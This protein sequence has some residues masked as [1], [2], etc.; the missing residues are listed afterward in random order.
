[1]ALMSER[2]ESEVTFDFDRS[3]AVNTD[4]FEDAQEWTLHD[5]IEWSVETM[6]RPCR[7]DATKSVSHSLLWCKTRAARRPGFYVFSIFV[8]M[9]RDA[10][11]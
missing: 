3:S 11:D 5:E 4:L 10:F 1:V 8:M 6:P 2:P 9:V 7:M